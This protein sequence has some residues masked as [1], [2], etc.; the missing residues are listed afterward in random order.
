MAWY[1]LYAS[2]VRRI[3]DLLHARS[4]LSSPSRCFA[5][6]RSSPADLIRAGVNLL[7]R[8]S[9]KNLPFLSATP[10]STGFFSSAAQNP[11]RAALGFFKYPTVFCSSRSLRA[12]TAPCVF[13]LA[14]VSSIP[15]SPQPRPLLLLARAPFSSSLCPV[16]EPPKVSGPHAPV[17]VLKT[18]DGHACAPDNLTGS[19]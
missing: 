7:Y 16:A 2:T 19:V 17:L 15:G 14:G 10:P 6:R 9:K 11:H 18:S 4:L 1:F 8:H 5:D 3:S 12:P 13:F